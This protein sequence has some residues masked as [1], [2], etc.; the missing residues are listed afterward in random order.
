[1]GGLIEYKYISDDV[2]FFFLLQ[3]GMHVSLHPS[4]LYVK[5]ISKKI[6]LKYFLQINISFWS[7]S[8]VVGNV[9]FL[10]NH[11]KMTLGNVQAKS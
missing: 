8:A 4:R 6:F 11:L 2:I 3:V 5:Q 9:F 1:M 7:R 10:G